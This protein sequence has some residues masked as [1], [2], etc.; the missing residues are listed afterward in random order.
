MKNSDTKK[1]DLL[2][3]KKWQPSE[4]MIRFYFDEKYIQINISK[5]NAYYKLIGFDFEPENEGEIRSQISYFA[6]TETNKVYISKF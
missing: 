2:N 5:G 6:N 3:G 4:N 1:I